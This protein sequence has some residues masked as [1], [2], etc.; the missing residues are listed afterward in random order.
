MLQPDTTG[1]YIAV[2]SETGAY[3]EISRRQ[4]TLV[5]PEPFTTRHWQRAKVNG[6]AD[7]IERANKSLAKIVEKW[8]YAIP[9][10]DAQ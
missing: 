6:D 4:Y 7:A 9:K 10:Q 2:C 1:R 3:L 8:G 5:L